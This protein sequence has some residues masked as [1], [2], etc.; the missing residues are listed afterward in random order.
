MFMC[1]VFYAI[2]QTRS[3]S[4]IQDFARFWERKSKCFHNNDHIG[5]QL[6]KSNSNHLRERVMRI[7]IPAKRHRIVDVKRMYIH[8]Y[9]CQKEKVAKHVYAKVTKWFISICFYSTFVF[10]ILTMIFS[11]Y[12]ICHGMMGFYGLCNPNENMHCMYSTY[13]YCY[14][15]IVFLFEIAIFLFRW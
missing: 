11:S 15:G 1:S 6:D 13:R 8:K 5:S 7:S 12:L 10:L 4:N 14:E 9:I 2:K 3:C